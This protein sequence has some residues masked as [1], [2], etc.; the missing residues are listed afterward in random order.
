M[1][2][3][4]SSARSVEPEVSGDHC[5]VGATES[6]LLVSMLEDVRF[7]KGLIWTMMNRLGLDR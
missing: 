1:L 6:S 2:E 5:H 7:F 3:L 4:K